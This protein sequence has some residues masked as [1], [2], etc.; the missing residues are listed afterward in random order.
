[1]PGSGAV[2]RGVATDGLKDRHRAAIVIALAANGR[3]ERAVL[4]GSRAMG[5][6]RAASDIDIAL[7]GDDLTDTD[8]A[9]LGAAM[10]ALPMAET[11]DML[12]H[13]TI[14]NPTLREH[15]AR[16]GVEWYRKPDADRPASRMAG[17][18]TLFRE[19]WQ[20]S[21]HVVEDVA[22]KDWLR[23]TL[24]DHVTVHTEQITP[25]SFPAR[26]F[27]HHSIPAFDDAQTSAIEVGAEIKSNKFTVPFDAV[28]VSRLN[29]RFPRVWS[30]VVSDVF[31]AIC[32]MEFL[33]MRPQTIDRR[34]LHYLCMAPSFRESLLERVTGT[35]SSHQRV[36]PKSMLEVE[37]SIPLLTEQRA[38]AAVLGAL[39]DKIE[40]NRRMN[41]TLEAMARAIFRDWFVDFGP[42]RA[43]AEGRPPYLAPEVWSLFPDAL[44]DEGKPAGWQTYT[45]SVLAQHHRATLAPGTEPE[46]T[47]EHYSIPAYDA[48]Q[49]PAADLGASIKSNKTIVPE[50]AVL[51]SKLNP[52]I[53]RVWLPN[54][55]EEYLQVSSTEFLAFTPLIPATRNVLYCLFKSSRFRAEMVA[56]VTGTSK[57]H[58]R[59][60]PKSLLACKALS[61]DPRLLALFDETTSSMLNQLLWNR[62]ESRELV[63]VRD[64]LLPK[65]MSGEIRL[66]DA[67]SAVGAVL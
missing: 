23:S 58:Q 46:R 51:L 32:S 15:I 29:P 9:R 4:F 56:R 57:S 22:P 33:V 6:H 14:D 3:V 42:T 62:R 36:S 66:L 30:P 39:D 31:P 60:Q 48:G 55:N 40:L 28:L 19:S 49:E 38:I 13:R 54:Q 10:E 61:A 34:F 63:R 45:L 41:E 52:E 5:T 43:K 1:M 12:L 7:F 25:S 24:G 37:A 59:V 44:D 27:A 47:Y 67:E 35:S 8:V 11:V 17:S 21:A 2:S 16:H 20:R 50:S 26:L 65:L 18:T 64:L 53:E